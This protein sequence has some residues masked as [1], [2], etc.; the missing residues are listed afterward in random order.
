[1]PQCVLTGVFRVIMVRDDHPVFAAPARGKDIPELRENTN[2]LEIKL[3][4]RN[5]GRY[6]NIIHVAVNEA[7]TR[8]NLRALTGETPEEFVDRKDLDGSVSALNF[9]SPLTYAPYPHAEENGKGP[10]FFQGKF[11]SNRVELFL[12]PRCGVPTIFSFSF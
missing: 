10:R 3:A 9:D 4:C 2:V 12:L 5:T 1:M 7:E 11:K 6:S 8:H